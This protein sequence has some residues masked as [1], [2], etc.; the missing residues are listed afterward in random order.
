MNKM[1]NIWHER[2]FNWVVA[3]I[4]CSV[5]SVNLLLPSDIWQQ[6]SWWTL[7]QLMVVDTKSLPEPL[8]AYCQIDPMFI[9]IKFEIQKFPF[10]NI[11]SKML[12]AQWQPFCSGLN[13]LISWEAV[14]VFTRSSYQR[15]WS[16]FETT[17]FCLGQSLRCV[18]NCDTT[19]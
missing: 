3:Y 14:S 6:T 18:S 9:E 16:N 5:S 19:M 2:P 7:V 17:R 1:M 4:C 13:V 11:H 15:I 8:L 10:K 12:S